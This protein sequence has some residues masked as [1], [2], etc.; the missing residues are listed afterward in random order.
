MNKSPLM[1][2]LLGVLVISALASTGLCYLCTRNAIRLI[3]MQ[4]Q[5]AAAQSRAAFIGLL[6]KDAVEYSAKNQA[7]DPILEAAGVKQAKSAAPAST[8]KPAAK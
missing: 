7:I 2:F 6:V 3:E 1:T 8:N 5:V 4:T